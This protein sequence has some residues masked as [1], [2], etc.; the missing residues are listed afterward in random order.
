MWK[1]VLRGPFPEHETVGSLSVIAVFRDHRAWGRFNI[2]KL[3]ETLTRI[4]SVRSG[5]HSCVE[6]HEYLSPISVD[7]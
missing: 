2:V 3:F 4:T 1:V 5:K 6:R 7:S